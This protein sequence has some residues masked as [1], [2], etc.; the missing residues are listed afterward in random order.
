[1]ERVTASPTLPPI[2]ASYRPSIRFVGLMGAMTA[3]GA[4]SIDMYLPSLPAVAADL[5]TTTGAVQF[6]ISG[7][8]I[9]AAIGQLLVGPISDRF[10]RRAPALAGIALHV[11]TSLLCMVAPTIG[12]LIALRMLQGVGNSAASVTAMAVIRDR[13]TGSAAAR[14]LSRLILVIGIA[15]LL[16][17]TIGGLVAGVAGWRAVFGVL[18]LL[19][20]VLL[21]IVWRFLPETHPA[22]ARTSP[23]VGTALRGYRS[24]LV[25]R[26]FMALAVLP[27]LGLSVVLCYVAAAPFVLQLGYGLTA[28]EFALIFAINGAGVVLMSQVNAALLT[29]IA[30]A[31][32]LRVAL[33]TILVVAVVVL[34]VSA[35][36]TGGLFG[37]LVPL[38]VLLSLHI[39]IPPNAKALAL[40][41][42]G[43]RAGTAAALIGALTVGIAGLVSTLVGVVGG[44]ATAMASVIVGAL[45]VALVVAVVGTPAYRRAGAGVEAPS[46]RDDAAHDPGAHEPSAVQRRA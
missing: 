37:L 20:M 31:H 26:R 7:V 8:L 36:G 4:L 41:L 39:F 1:M 13:L 29:R 15:P 11:V 18:A 44:D 35:T 10:G 42:R 19:G 30:P 17:P 40:T 43:E 46:G 45:V 21:V 14:V 33:P 38:W 3:L 23:G 2:P 9:G 34:A 25:D 16:A 24:L 12:A 27:G 5:G 28:R 22:E 32:M 6:T